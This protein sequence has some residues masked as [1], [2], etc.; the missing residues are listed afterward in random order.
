MTAITYHTFAFEY[1]DRL[2][3]R[4]CRVCQLPEQNARAQKLHGP[5]PDARDWRSRAYDQDANEERRAA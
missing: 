4:W 2:G 3:R 1:R 5:I